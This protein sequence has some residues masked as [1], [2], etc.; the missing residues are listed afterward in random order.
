MVVKPSGKDKFRKVTLP[1]L[2]RAAFSQLQAAGSWSKHHAWTPTQTASISSADRGIMG[3]GTM[4][5]LRGP[6]DFARVAAIVFLLGILSMSQAAP[7]HSST[8]ID[9]FPCASKSVGIDMKEGSGVQY[10][11][12]ESHKTS[13]ARFLACDLQ[14][15]QRS[16]FCDRKLPIDERTENLVSLLTL[17][18]KI[19]LLA[20]NAGE[21]PRLGLKAYEWWGEALHGVAFSPGTDFDGPIKCVTSFPQVIGLG[22]SFN[23][24]LWNAVGQVSMVFYF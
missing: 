22:A 15:A 4:S 9:A 20:N 23:R 5:L 19:G 2:D 13:R 1:S 10:P 21:V 17:K 11:V 3:G 24:T 16:T 6:P 8:S 14:Q 12:A 7:L 18:E